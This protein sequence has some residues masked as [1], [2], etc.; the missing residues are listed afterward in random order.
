MVTG[1]DGP[2]IGFVACR[3][4]RAAALWIHGTSP[5][6]CIGCPGARQEPDMLGKRLGQQVQ[7]T[8][9]YTYLACDSIQ[10]A[11]ACIT[12]QHRSTL[13]TVRKPAE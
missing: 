9:R 4:E 13:L 10:S 11:V 7:P 6:I 12:G 2:G 1:E 3:R 8:T 5:D